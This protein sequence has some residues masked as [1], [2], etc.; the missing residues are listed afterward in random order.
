MAQPRQYINFHD[1]VIFGVPHLR[2]VPIILQYR[3]KRQDVT[4]DAPCPRDLLSCCAFG[5]NVTYLRYRFPYYCGPRKV[6]CTAMVAR[7]E[8]RI[9]LAPSQDAIAVDL[10]DGRGFMGMGINTREASPDPIALSSCRLPAWQDTGPP[11]DW[12][13]ESPPIKFATDTNCHSPY[14][15][16]N[17]IQATRC[18]ARPPWMR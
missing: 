15:F 5:I 13:T 8:S 11:G 1:F 17:E 10:S 12:S 4:T 14:S 6:W 3:E 7:V 9:L 18:W 2:N 16:S